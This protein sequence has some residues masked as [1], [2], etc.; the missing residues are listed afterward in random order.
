MQTGT[1]LAQGRT[2]VLTLSTGVKDVETAWVFYYLGGSTD[3]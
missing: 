2:S 1:I 3:L